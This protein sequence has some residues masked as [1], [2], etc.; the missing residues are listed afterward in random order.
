MFL[1][2]CA[3]L[4]ACTLVAL[5]RPL[6]PR[7]RS[8]A[9]RTRSP[10]RDPMSAT[11]TKIAVA[12]NV[13]E[14]FRMLLRAQLDHARAQRFRGALR[15]GTGRRTSKSSPPTG[16]ATHEVPLTR[17]FRPRGRPARA[18]RAGATLPARALRPGAHPHA[19]DGAARPARRAPRRRPQDRQHRARAL[20]SRRRG[21]AATD[22]AGDDRPRH[23][24]ALVGRP[25]AEPRGRRA[26]RRAADVPARGHP[27]PRAGHRSRALRSRAA[28]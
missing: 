24:R 1:Q 17:L 12:A 22:G 5:W 2:D 10:R 13:P 16:F 8:R 9:S 14:S 4:G 23:L 7:A 19:E 6:R 15:R 18:A 21:G 26:R 28:C 27:S 3:L 11:T 20:E 25:V